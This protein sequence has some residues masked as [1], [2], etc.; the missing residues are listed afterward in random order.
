MCS[1]VS[2]STGAPS[3]FSSA[4]APSSVL[5]T[6][7][8][9]SFASSFAMLPSCPRQ[10]SITCSKSRLFSDRAICCANSSF[11]RNSR[12]YLRALSSSFS[13]KRCLIRS[14]SAFERGIGETSVSGYMRA[15]PGR[16]RRY[17]EHPSSKARRVSS[18][19][20]SV[21]SLARSI[22]AEIASRQV[23]ALSSASMTA[24]SASSASRN[25]KR[26]WVS[27]SVIPYRGN[28]SV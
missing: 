24:A 27:C 7:V 10:R 21:D 6:S 26:A 2:L 22:T 13:G 12:L 17:S 15:A 23:L 1:R 19:T 28:S 11:R 9:A 20:P 8:A 18:G 25:C 14:M 4:M 16:G 5:T 3:L